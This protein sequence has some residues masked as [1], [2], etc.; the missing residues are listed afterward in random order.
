MKKSVLAIALCSLAALSSQA[1]AQQT[2]EGSWLVRVRA[3]NLDPS[4][5]SDPINGAG[6]SDRLTI[7]SKVI[8]ELDISYFFTPNWAT[9]LVLTYP[10]K[11][12]VSLD[13]A[14][15]GTF[16]HLPPTLTLQ[17][18]FTP[19]K[20]ISPYVGAGINYTRISSVDIL[21][22]AA[23]LEK[24]SVGLALQAGVDFKIDKNWS[25][26]LD[27]KKV[28]IRSDVNTAAGQLSAVK[29]DPWLIGVGVGYRF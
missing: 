21:N 13:G 15:I 11:Q 5:K 19:E 16:K 14:Q 29:I 3:V 12:K 20:T 2:Q 24:S 22:G 28:Q 10:Q 4:N 8:P 17:Y 23:R 7:N 6:A 27:V 25:I 1:F 26:N 18:H 9:E